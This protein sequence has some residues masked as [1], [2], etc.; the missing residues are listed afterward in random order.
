LDAPDADLFLEDQPPLDHDH[1]L[2]D[3]HDGGVALGANGRDS[4]H[5]AADRHPLDLDALVG[6]HLV[7]DQL[8]LVREVP[9]A[10]WTVWGAWA[11]TSAA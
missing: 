9:P 2:H 3:R 8:A 7:H 1:F 10:W 11:V 5:D 4:V 6:Q